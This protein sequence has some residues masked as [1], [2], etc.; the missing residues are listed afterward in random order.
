MLE[1]CKTGTP[2]I[3]FF[4][5]SSSSSLYLHWSILDWGSI[6]C[7]TSYWVSSQAAE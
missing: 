2:G 4:T 7:G 3:Q 6:D 1:R 5:S